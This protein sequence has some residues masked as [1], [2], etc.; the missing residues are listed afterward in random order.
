MESEDTLCL[1][2]RKRVEE[3]E[4]EE[5]E[6]EEDKH[7]H[8]YS[9]LDNDC[10]G[11]NFLNFFGSEEDEESFE[12]ILSLPIDSYLSSSTSSSD[13]PTA[14]TAEE[15]E[16][17]DDDEDESKELARR[18]ENNRKY[19]Q[20]SRLRKKTCIESLRKAVKSLESE[21]DQLK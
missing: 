4:E 15:E 8:E 14:A 2:K 19:A 21:N 9:A 12:E 20:K 18:R 6:V 3:D 5:E 13:V 7:S 16:D 17:D 10:V 11:F 1:M